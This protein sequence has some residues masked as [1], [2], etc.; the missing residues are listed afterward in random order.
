MSEERCPR[1][2]TVDVEWVSDGALRYGCDSYGWIKTGEVYQQSDTCEIRELTAKLATL[3]AA[4]REAVDML[5]PRKWRV[6][7]AD[8]SQKSIDAFDALIKR[9]REEAE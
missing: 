5:E 7:N 1:C 9:L 6:L 2:G 3:R 8:P 4:A